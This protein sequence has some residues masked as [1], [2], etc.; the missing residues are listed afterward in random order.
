MWP[1][2]EADRSL[3]FVPRLRMDTAI[4]ILP[5]LPSLSKRERLYIY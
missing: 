4:T 5:H 1:E 3:Q 2:R